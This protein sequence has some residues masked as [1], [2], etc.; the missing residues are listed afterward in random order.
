[1]ALVAGVED[2]DRGLGDRRTPA[3]HAHAQRVP[4]L[5]HEPARVH[6]L[7]AR[8]LYVPR[9]V[10]G[11]VPPSVRRVKAEHAVAVLERRARTETKAP[12]GIGRADVVGL[13]RIGPGEEA[14]FGAGGRYPAGVADPPHQGPAHGPGRRGDLRRFDRIRGAPETG[15]R[16][17]GHGAELFDRRAGRLGRRVAA[18]ELRK[19]LCR[20]EDPDDEEHEDGDQLLHD[21]SPHQQR[22]ER[23]IRRLGPQEQRRGP[24]PPIA[25]VLGVQAA[26][27][28]REGPLDPGADGLDGN[29]QMRRNP[30]RRQV[31]EVAEEQ[32]LAVRLL[33][34]QDVSSD[35]LGLLRP[36]GQRVGRRNGLMRVVLRLSPSAPPFRTGPVLREIAH[37]RGQPGPGRADP[38]GRVL[39]GGEIGLLRQVVRRLGIAH[40]R[41]RQAAEPE[42]LLEQAVEGGGVGVHG[43]EG[44]DATVRES[45]SGSAPPSI[46]T[47]DGQVGEHVPG[48]V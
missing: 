43:L 23:R 7:L 45:G 31:L 28:G 48:T 42:A 14:H 46:G 26:P 35:A 29:A 24:R 44:R 47:G 21:E 18:G 15:R 33:E 16:G 12:A 25:P 30:A 22:D 36:G 38:R 41:A 17:L 32:D 8:H 11:D 6:V 39:D 4:L 1:M 27:Q 34:G 2:L 40:E 37:H 3:L 20:Q 13:P 5:Q 9:G 10:R 19:P